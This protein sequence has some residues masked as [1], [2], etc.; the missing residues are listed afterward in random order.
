[1]ASVVEVFAVSMMVTTNNVISQLGL[2]DPGEW[3]SGFRFLKITKPG[4]GLPFTNPLG[5]ILPFNSIFFLL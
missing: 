3:I 4:C 1:M 2:S 5:S